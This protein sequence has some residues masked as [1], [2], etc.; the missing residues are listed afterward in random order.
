[1]ESK[2]ALTPDERIELMSR[3]QLEFDARVKRE[4]LKQCRGCNAYVAD[5]DHKRFCAECATAGP[6]QAMNDDL[7]T[8]AGLHD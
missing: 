8:L 5:L 1:M 2:R 3:L 7:F 4:H 6:V